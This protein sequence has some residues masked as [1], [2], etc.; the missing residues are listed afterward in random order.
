MQPM[1]PFKEGGPI[2]PQPVYP[3]YEEKAE[4]PDFFYKLGP[5]NFKT[6]TAYMSGDALKKM[7]KAGSVYPVCLA[8]LER[9]KEEIG[10][11]EAKMSKN[12]ISSRVTDLQNATQL[13]K[14]QKD[15]PAWEKLCPTLM[16][17]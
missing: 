7:S 5:D 8:C 2:I 16:V 6:G 1:L 10:Q 14:L 15:I 17:G 11:V 12:K 4:C 9:A 13:K 3:K